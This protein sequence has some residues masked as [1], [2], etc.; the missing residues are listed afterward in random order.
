MCRQWRFQHSGSTRPSTTLYIV[1]R[2]L[3]CFA[4]LCYCCNLSGGV[5]LNMWFTTYGMCVKNNPIH[6]CGANK[7]Q[8]S[9]RGVEALP[10]LTYERL[11]V[12][13]SVRGEWSWHVNSIVAC[14]HSA[15]LCAHAARDFRSQHYHPLHWLRLLTLDLSIGIVSV[16]IFSFHVGFRAIC[17]WRESKNI[18]RNN[19]SL[20]YIRSLFPRAHPLESEL[21]SAIKYF[22]NLIN[23]RLNVFLKQWV[24]I[25]HWIWIPIQ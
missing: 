4:F 3:A 5:A 2:E 24:C 25:E 17:R 12:M 6:T 13:T 20:E 16:H 19:G 9:D 11:N 10:I 8:K 14:C 15:K 23:I 22:F 21:P 7:Q 1:E 18:V